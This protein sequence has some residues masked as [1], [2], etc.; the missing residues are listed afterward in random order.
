[1]KKQDSRTAL[2]LPATQREKMDALVEEGKYRNLSEVVRSA[3]DQ[4]LKAAA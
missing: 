2:R 1:M 3:L 4:F